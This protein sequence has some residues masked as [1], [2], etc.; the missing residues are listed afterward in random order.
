VT[1]VSIPGV[2]G[3]PTAQ[4][5]GATTT[6]L[7][8]W[9]DSSGSGDMGMASV[10]W[11]GT[12]FLAQ[13]VATSSLE[14]YPAVNSGMAAISAPDE[15]FFSVNPSH[16]AYRYH[17]IAA[18]DVVWASSPALNAFW[19]IYAQPIVSSGTVFL[20]SK[21]LMG[22]G[23]SSGTQTLA[24][25]ANAAAG[26]VSAPT[27]GSGG[28]VY[29]TDDQSELVALNVSAA[30]STWIYTGLAASSTKLTGVG[31]EATLDSDGTLYFGDGS[32]RVFAIITDSSGPATAGTGDWPRTGFDN[33]N[34][35]SAWNVGYTCQ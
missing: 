9:N 20:A 34:S 15:L 33:C 7:V 17:T 24:I 1:A 29:Y 35:G 23:R 19:N 32:G 21:K 5:N 31:T 18:S 14:L 26:Q 12:E 4:V 22:Y 28:L 8:G 27:V 6:V 2:V 25:T 30:T 13:S 11:S 3:P 16:V 10:I